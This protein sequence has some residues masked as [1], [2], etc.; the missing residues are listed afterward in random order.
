MECM[1]IDGY[2]ASGF[3]TG[4]RKLQQCAEAPVLSHGGGQPT[5]NQIITWAMRARY[6]PP[7]DSV[8]EGVFA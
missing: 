6:V 4:Y 1:I 8:S 5:V 3:L 7:V 2:I